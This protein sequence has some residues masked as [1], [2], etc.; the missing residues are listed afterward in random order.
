MDTVR[1]SA[2]GVDSISVFCKKT[3]IFRNWKEKKKEENMFFPS[4][5]TAV[6]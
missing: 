6:A 3:V 4:L 5:K 1:E 2:L